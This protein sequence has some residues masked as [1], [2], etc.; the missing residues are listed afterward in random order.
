LRIEQLVA[1]FAVGPWDGVVM[2]SANAARALGEHPRRGE[3]LGLSYSL[4]GK[5]PRKRRG[6]VGSATFS[7]PM[8]MS[9]TCKTCSCGYRS[10]PV[11]ANR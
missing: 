11:A 3:L 4:S 2:T 7:R 9:P 1:D 8:A 10:G 6:P 5:R